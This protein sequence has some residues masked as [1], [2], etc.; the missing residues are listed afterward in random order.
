MGFIPGL[1]TFP[2]MLLG[3]INMGIG[4]IA[5]GIV[6]QKKVQLPQEEEVLPE[7]SEREQIENYLHVDPLEIEIGYSLIPLIDVAALLGIKFYLKKQAYLKAWF[8]SAATIVFCTFFGVMGLFPN[9]F[10]SSIDPNYSLTAMN[11]SSSP[12]TLKIMLVVVILFIPVV[13]VYQIWTYIIFKGKL[14]SEDLSL[15]EAY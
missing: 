12:L 15:E 10:P 8:A 14:T 3:I 2:F 7:P 9:L 5:T 6:A 13:I 4:Y 11:A 1:P